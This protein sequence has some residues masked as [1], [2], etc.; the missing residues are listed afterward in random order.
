MRQKKC[1]FTEHKTIK[2]Y[3]EYGVGHFG[4]MLLKTR[5]KDV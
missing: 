1:C 3:Y 5:S 2:R 4:C